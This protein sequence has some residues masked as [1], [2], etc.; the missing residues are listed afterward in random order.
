MRNDLIRAVLD[1]GVD[2]LG[3]LDDSS[4]CSQSSEWFYILCELP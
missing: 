4:A 2:D 3:M 1:C